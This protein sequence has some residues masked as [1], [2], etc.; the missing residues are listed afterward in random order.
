MYN[1]PIGEWKR[2]GE[3]LVRLGVKHYGWDTATLGS[4]S[5][6]STVDRGSIEVVGKEC[7]GWDKMEGAL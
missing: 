6:A 4:C 3:V 2:T 1:K 5:I 7:V